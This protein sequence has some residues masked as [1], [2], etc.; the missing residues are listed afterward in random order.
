MQQNHPLKTTSLGLHLIF[1]TTIT[2]I[3][4]IL[5][6]IFI[7][8]V[9]RSPS[10]LVPI[11]IT[12]IFISVLGMIGKVLCAS[13]PSEMTGKGFLYASIAADLFSFIPVLFPTILARSFFKS[14]QVFL[15]YLTFLIYS[16]GSSQLLSVLLLV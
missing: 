16:S 12:S 7:F 6:S 9:V 11:S 15:Y 14:R 8:F 10:I 2:G 13:A 1:I 5:L 3:A 4:L